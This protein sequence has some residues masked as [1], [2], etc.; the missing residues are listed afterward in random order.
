MEVQNL[1]YKTDL[2]NSS[3]IT[4]NAYI[5]NTKLHFHEKRSTKRTQ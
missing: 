1:F 4:T 5:T 3:Q 2:A